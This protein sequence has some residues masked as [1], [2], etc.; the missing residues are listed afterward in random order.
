MN[1]APVIQAAELSRWY[2]IV[3]GLNNVSFEI[4]PGLTGLVGPNGAG[5]STLIKIITG[6]LQPSNGELTVFGQHPWNNPELLRQVGFCPEE[7]ALPDQ[8]P[9]RTWLRGLALLAGIVPDTVPAHVDA[10]LDCV[11]LDRLHWE[12]PLSQF[13]KGMRQRVKLAQA[14]LHRP[15][16]LVLDEPMNGLDP[17]GR[18]D[19]QRILRQ[20][21]AEGTAVLISSHILHELEVL[22]PEILM[23][24]WGRVIASGT[25][26]ALQRRLQGTEANLHVKCSDPAR[27]TQ[28]LFE[29][30]FLLGFDDT[31]EEG[32][33]NLRIKEPKRFNE[34][35]VDLL[36]ENDVALHELRSRDRS[37]QDIFEKM[38]E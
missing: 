4:G 36:A 35:F 31:G 22:C 33:L 37:L 24:N 1:A 12:K 8:L 26:L 30:G 13:S 25:Q 19:I 7:D 17:M 14:L 28:V 34:T 27:L 15:R 6:Q 3:M 21:A 29:A 23:L 16:L 18:Q 5:K 2:G 11:K 9:A 20:L 38:T 10:M 32:G